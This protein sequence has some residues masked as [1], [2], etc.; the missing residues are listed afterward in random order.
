MKYILLIGDGMA[1]NP[2]EALGGLTPLE[3]AS[4]PAID[5]LAKRGVLGSVK[6]V[7]N[8]FEPGSDTAIMSIFGCT[9]L[10]YYSGRAPLELAAMD[11]FLEPGDSA[12]RCN[13]VA[14]SEGGSFEKRTILS[15]SGGGIPGSD[16]RALAEYL[17]GHPDFKAMSDELGLEIKLTSSYR[18]L[19]IAHG[20]D[21]GGTHFSPPHDHLDETV[22]DNLPSGTPVAAKLSVLLEKAVELLENHPINAARRTDGKLPANAAWFWA[23]G[24]AA[25]LPSFHGQYNKTGSVIS[26]VGLVQGIA[27]LAGLDVI[28]VD[29]ATGELETNY[30]GKVEAALTAAKTRDFVALHVEAPDECSHAGDVP[31]KL[32]AIEWFDSRVVAPVI[33]GLE[34]TGEDFRV[35]I[36]ADHKTLCVERTHDG[37]PVPFIIYDSRK[38][39]NAGLPYTEKNGEAGIY[40]DDGSSLMGMLFEQ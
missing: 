31:G 12:M 17:F 11:I 6:T 5:S 25:A 18:H 34:A 29:G 26:A 30:E 40:I 20:V 22:L 27:K 9:P 24:T 35:L 23:A 10:K 36:L 32:Q 7:P 19:V 39:T 33:N 8:G 21:L 28:I 13:N 37:D 38:D 15:H 2:L 4:I 16:G 1:E 3:K 14:L